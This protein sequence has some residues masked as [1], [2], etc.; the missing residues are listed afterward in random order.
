VIQSIQTLVP[1]LLT[2][3]TTCLAQVDH[4]GRLVDLVFFSTYITDTLHR[5]SLHRYTIHQTIREREFD[6]TIPKNIQEP[7]RSPP[8]LSQPYIVTRFLVVRL[9][10]PVHFILRDF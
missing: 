1:F 2:C 8:D 3:R 5:R 7:T 10:Y 6:R 9:S 4:V